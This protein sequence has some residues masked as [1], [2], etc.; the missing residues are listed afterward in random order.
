MYSMYFL[1][2]KRV[3]VYNQLVALILK[4]NVKISA[5]S[6]FLSSSNPYLTIRIQAGKFIRSQ[7][8]ANCHDHEFSSLSLSTI[9]QTHI[10]GLFSKFC[11]F[12]I[13]I[14]V[15]LC[16]ILPVKPCHWEFDYQDE[17][18]LRMFVGGSSYKVTKKAKCQFLKKMQ[19]C[20]DSLHYDENMLQ[21]WKLSVIGNK[22]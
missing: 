12:W 2:C 17:K 13:P 9:K 11:K 6:L 21:V 20:F 15:I 22:H 3:L 16:S 8:I 4:K 18:L 7:I 14:I 5:T 19:I 1:T 10:S